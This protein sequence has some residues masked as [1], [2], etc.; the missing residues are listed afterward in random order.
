MKTKNSNV[1]NEEDIEIIEKSLKDKNSL[2]HP[3]KIPSKEEPNII[4]F[5]TERYQTTP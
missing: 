2:N 4:Y 1:P 3:Y 5:V